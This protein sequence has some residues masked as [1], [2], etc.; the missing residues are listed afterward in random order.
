MTQYKFFSLLL[1]PFLSCGSVKATEIVEQAHNLHPLRT[2]I[3]SCDP[4]TVV[5]SL[6][7]ID[8]KQN[9]NSLRN[10]MYSI[11]QLAGE[12]ITIESLEQLKFLSSF[13][14]E[15]DLRETYL[16]NH[17]LEV[18]FETG[19]DNLRKLYI[20]ENNFDD[21]GLKHIAN[22]KNLIEL[23]LVYNKITHTGIFNILPISTLE[24]LDIGCTYIDDK[25]IEMLSVMENIKKLD[26]RACNLNDST[27][28]FL[29]N[30]KKLE[31]VNISD[32]NFSQGK[33][34]NFLEMA[35]RR[36]I[37]VINNPL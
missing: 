13:I 33:L 1:L 34:S 31:W 22:L 14:Y 32:N 15:L 19:F 2:N 21:D 17:H 7:G 37:T 12:E 8:I 9:L 16:T 27:L 20:S 25:G 3:R 4:D 6:D 24:F 30:M 10:P 26:I 36:N 35:S 5:F 29:L 23:S 18:L 11:D 28:D